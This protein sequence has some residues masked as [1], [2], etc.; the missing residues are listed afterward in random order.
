MEQE[1]II[2]R[3]RG[4]LF[5]SLIKQETAF[6]DECSTGE[7]VSVLTADTQAIADDLTWVFRFSIEAI[8]RISFITGS[9]QPGVCCCLPHASLLV[10]SS[11]IYAGFM[12]YRDYRLGLDA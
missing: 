3:V 5:R 4:E 9:Q 10:T 11:P 8:A 6:F 7:L 12:I 1:R 2:L